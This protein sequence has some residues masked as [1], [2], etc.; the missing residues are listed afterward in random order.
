MRFCLLLS[1]CLLLVTAATPFAAETSLNGTTLLMFEQ[2]SLPGFDTQNIVPATQ[3]ISLESTGVGTPNLSIHLNAWGRIDLADDSTDKSSDGTLSYGYLLFHFP[4]SDSAIKAGRIWVFEGVSSENIDGLYTRIGLAKGFT[5][6]AFGGAPVRPD[7]RVDNRGDYIT[8]GRFSYT[9]PSVFELGLST[10]YENGLNS[11]PSDDIRDSR[12]LAGADVWLKPHK[13][14]DLRGRISYD[15]INNGISEQSW[16]AA[17]RIGSSS[18]LTAD[19]NQYEFEQYFAASAIRSLFNPDATGGQKNLGARFTHQLAKPLEITASYRHFDRDDT[20]TADRYGAEGRLS[21]LDGKGLYG[22]SYFRV[23]A[24][25]EFNSYHQIR[26]F[27]HYT[28]ANYSAGID[29]IADLYDDQVNGKDSGFEIQASAGYRFMPG[30]NLSCDVSYGENPAYDSEFKGLLRL[31]FN[32]T[33][34]RGTAR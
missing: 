27:L 30:L 34:G 20:G 12:Q 29:G 31:T 3:F 22:L 28:A 2:R 7:N 24:P 23:D 17:L 19:Y 9:Y 14:F 6:S 13:R 5:L 4:K 15:M 16:Q 1:I 32:Y 11:G 25:A 18:T 33:T 26:S 8:G 10:V 21:F